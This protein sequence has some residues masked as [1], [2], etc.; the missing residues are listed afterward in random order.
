[1]SDFIREIVD[2][3]A[4][5]ET[6]SAA[7]LAKHIDWLEHAVLI[8]RDHRTKHAKEPEKYTTILTRPFLI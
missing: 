4:E 6:L 2:G 1:M 5:V 3:A 8:N 7:S